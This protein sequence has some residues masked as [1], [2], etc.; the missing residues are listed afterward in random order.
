MLVLFREILFKKNGT[1]KDVQPVLWIWTQTDPRYAFLWIR[2]F[3]K[4]LKI[5]IN[6]IYKEDLK[7]KKCMNIKAL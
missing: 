1:D 4:A 6:I 7:H 2:F 5:K 3:G